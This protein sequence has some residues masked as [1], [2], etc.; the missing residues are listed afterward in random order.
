MSTFGVKVNVIGN[1]GGD[2]AL[3][4]V[5]YVKLPANDAASLVLGNGVVEGGGF[6]DGAA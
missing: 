4:F 5:P 6:R 1:D 2:I 3:S